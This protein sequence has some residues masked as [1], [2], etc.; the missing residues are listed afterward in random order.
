MEISSSLWKNLLPITTL[1]T[2]VF[3]VKIVAL[4][5]YNNYI[6]WSKLQQ[7]ENEN[8]EILESD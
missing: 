2:I 1:A 7:K 8:L 6:V 5:L 3:I 4:L